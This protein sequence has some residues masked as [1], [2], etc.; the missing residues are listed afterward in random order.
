MRHFGPVAVVDVRTAER[1]SIYDNVPR[2]LVVKLA[3]RDRFIR[4]VPAVGEHAA[5]NA[6][7]QLGVCHLF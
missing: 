1:R 7:L 5:E 3:R 6:V 4:P 2:Q